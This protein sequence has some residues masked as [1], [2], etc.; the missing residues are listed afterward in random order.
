M[1]GQNFMN[2]SRA[3]AACN[4]CRNRRTKCI[5]DAGERS[6]NYC[7]RKGQ[8]CFFRAIDE[9]KRPNSRTYVKSLLDNIESLERRLQGKQREVH[10]PPESHARTQ[11]SVDDDHD[12]SRSSTRN[13]LFSPVHVIDMDMDCAEGELEES[14]NLSA[15]DHPSLPTTTNAQTTSP[16]VGQS[17]VQKNS[18]WPLIF[19]P[20]RFMYVKERAR[21]EYFTPA[22]CY[23]Y[24]A[25]D[26]VSYDSWQEDNQLRRVLDD[27]APDLDTYLMGLFW[28]RYNNT[29]F[30]IDQDAFTNDRINRGTTYY[31]S[32]LHLVCLAVASRFA[33]RNHKGMS[34]ISLSDGQSTFQREAKYILHRVLEEPR[35]LTLVQALLVL[36]DVE[37]SQGRY[38]LTAIHISTACRLAFEFGLNLDSAQF[39]LSE[40]ERRFRKNLLRSCIIHDW[41]WAMHGGRPANIKLADISPSYFE[42][43]SNTQ[44]SR[45]DDNQAWT[46]NSDRS[47]HEQTLDALIELSGYSSQ[48]QNLVQPRLIPETIA[49]ENRLTD[50]TFLDARLKTWYSTLPPRL[51][52][53][54]ENIK[55]ASRLYFIMHQQLHLSQLILHGAYGRYEDAVGLKPQSLE[56]FGGLIRDDRTVTAWQH[57]ARSLTMNAALKIVQSFSIYRQRFSTGQTGVLAFQQAATAFPALM[58]NIKLCK[59]SRKRSLA[60][61]NLFTLMHEAQD[62]SLT[63]DPMQGVCNVVKREMNDLGI[64][65]AE[66]KT[67]LTPIQQ[68][69]EPIIGSIQSPKTP[70]LEELSHLDVATTQQRPPKYPTDHGAYGGLP[71]DDNVETIPTL[72]DNMPSARPRHSSSHSP[73]IPYSQAFEDSLQTAFPQEPGEV[74]GGMPYFMSDLHL[75]ETW[76]IDYSGGSPFF[77]ATDQV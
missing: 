31:S 53:T 15:K 55:T 48:I 71:N 30:V 66:L 41:A 28:S 51:M 60:L 46:R 29:L 63:Y 64:D 62:M 32:F 11:T 52:W 38:D 61:E 9:R 34:Q 18:I 1:S 59:D 47:L 40:S 45:G 36:S 10:V 77:D 44:P 22:S 2:R 54:A 27:V 23:Q 42:P 72:S 76:S 58:C 26:R 24:F 57:I 13:H 70:N 17:G 68:P 21:I 33:D 19:A 75:G 73:A 37:F 43:K 16:G 6:C 8:D 56:I 3:S 25:Q 5:T 35:S 65:F 74:W 49:D 67:P 69:N 4:A 12:F 39:D 20:G 14:S 7:R 50:V